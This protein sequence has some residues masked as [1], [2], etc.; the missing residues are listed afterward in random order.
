MLPAYGSAATLFLY[1][2][3]CVRMYVYRTRQQLLHLLLPH[4]SGTII[5]IKHRSNRE[6]R[7]RVEYYI[8]RIYFRERISRTTTKQ[9]SCFKFRERRKK[10]RGRGGNTAANDDDDDDDAER[11]RRRRG[12]RRR[13]RKRV[14]RKER[15]ENRWLCQSQDTISEHGPTE[16]EENKV[17]R[18]Y[19]CVYVCKKEREST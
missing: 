3:V 7:G 15:G 12:R 18:V 6:L 16:R 10:E 8:S 1:I 17:S 14:G 13:G 4:P 9:E 5:G 11:R 2:Y 19:V